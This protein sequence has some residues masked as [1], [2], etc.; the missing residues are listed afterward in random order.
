MPGLPPCIAHNLS[1]GVVAYDI[2]LIIK[3][4]VHKEW[5][6]EQYLNSRIKQFKFDATAAHSKALPVKFTA[7]KLSGN[8]SQN[9][10][11]ILFFPLSIIFKVKDF[12][13]PVWKMLLL[14]RQIVEITCVPL[15]AFSQISYLV[16]LIGEYLELRSTL[17][18]SES[19]KPKHHY[20]A[21]YSWL[22]YQLGPLI[23]LW[24]L[25]FER[26]HA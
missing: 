17:F 25:R 15:I 10:C 11:F 8:A 20:M 21:L 14:L 23:Y 2:M 12:A 5:F 3:Y 4:F 18:P 6:S 26:K 13:D 19:I 16:L 22:I 7:K 9:R 24:T 1:E